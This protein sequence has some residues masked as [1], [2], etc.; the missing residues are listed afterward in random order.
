M[1]ISA[2]S[3]A[4]MGQAFAVG[5]LREFTD[6]VVGCDNLGACHATSLAEEEY[7]EGDD[8][9]IGDGTLSV[10][11]KAGPA[12]GDGLV[13]QL[14]I[15]GWASEPKLGSVQKLALDGRSI[16]VRL[17]SKDGLYS[18]DNRNSQRFIAA[19]RSARKIA[20]L[21]SRGQVVASAS[22]RGW[23]D[24]LTYI[25]TQQYRTGTTSALAS[26]GGKPWNYSVIP[27]MVPQQPVYLPPR[28]DR[29]ASEVDETQLTTLKALDPCIKY[30]EGATAEPPEYI[31]LDDRHSLM[32]LPTTCGGYNPYRMLLIVDENGRSSNAEFWPY[33]GNAMLED[34]EL[35]DV[36]WDERARRLLSF[37]RGRSL[38]DC[39]EASEY[40]WDQGK[41][42]LVN[43]KSM[44][45]CRSGGSYD[46][47]T[48][49]RREVVD[50]SETTVRK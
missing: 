17:S 29:P 27:P 23:R 21:D 10:S 13:I 41:F 43:F 2:V 8:E 45:P 5:D 42:R 24:A 20:L 37:G 46:Y 9:P 3:L 44:Y 35:P 15:M 19:S 47:I 34:P 1:L 12:P 4:L 48:T 39:G 14:A 49:Y 6:W 18:L 16:D 31:R 7:Q 50:S 33:P 40:V 32:I 30:S 25:D 36:R 22:L 28:T 38:A 26:T 11:L